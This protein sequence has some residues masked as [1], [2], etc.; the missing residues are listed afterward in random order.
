MK[1]FLL[2]CTMLVLLSSC[3]NKVKNMLGIT[4]TMPNE[5]QVTRNQSL[6]IP[7]HFNISE[8][9]DKNIS[10]SEKLSKTEKA[11]LNDIQ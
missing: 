9:N 8:L 1:Q 7:P 4:E 3:G 2:F 6:E 11:L 5:Y 10:K